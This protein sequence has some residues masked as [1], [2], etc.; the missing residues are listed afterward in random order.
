MCMHVSSVPHVVH[1][2]HSMNV[3]IL[4]KVHIIPTIKFMHEDPH[5]INNIKLGQSK[6]MVK[7]RVVNEKKIDLSGGLVIKSTL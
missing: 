1:M 5:A 4:F 7:K 3:I 6:M 2:F